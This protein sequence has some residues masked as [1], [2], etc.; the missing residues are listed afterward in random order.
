MP[1]KKDLKIIPGSIIQLNDEKKETL[2]YLCKCF[3]QNQDRANILMNQGSKIYDG[4]QK[5][6]WKTLNAMFPELRDWNF[7]VNGEEGKLIVGRLLT[8]HEKE[9]RDRRLGDN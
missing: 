2:K 6:F 4:A 1:K 5:D 8:I 7:S 3:D 9:K